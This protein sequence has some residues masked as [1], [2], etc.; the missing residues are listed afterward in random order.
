MLSLPGSMGGQRERH[1]LVRHKGG[2]ARGCAT[3][4]GLQK[5]IHSARLQCKQQTF[6]LEM[7]SFQIPVAVLVCI[8]AFSCNRGGSGGFAQGP[9]EMSGCVLLTERCE[10]LRPCH[11]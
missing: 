9:Q 1:A 10:N 11:M 4:A 5:S 8:K 3:L 6:R 7:I 2:I